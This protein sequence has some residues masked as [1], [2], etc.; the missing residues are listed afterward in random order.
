MALRRSFAALTAAALVLGACAPAPAPVPDP[1]NCEFVFRQLDR[2]LR[3]SPS[4][5]Y[6]VVEDNLVLRPQFSRLSVQAL[7]GGC[8]TFTDDLG[9]LDALRQQALAGRPLDTSPAIDPVPVHV[10]VVTSLVDEVMVL[11]FYRAL[12]Y[13]TRSFGVDGFG[14]RIYVGPLGTEGQLAEVID[15]ARRAGFVAPYVPRDFRM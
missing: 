12:G 6:S 1:E 11:S 10:G 13:R 5:Q 9:N 15:L 4:G 7:Q 14:R 2:E 3:F 8:L